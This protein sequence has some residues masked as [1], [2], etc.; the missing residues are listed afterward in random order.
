MEIFPTPIWI[1]DIDSIDN[2][3]LIDYSYKLQKR[4]PE[5]RDANG[6]RQNPT[7]LKWRSWYL[8][9]L[10]FSECT[11]LKKLFD[12]VN[13]KAELAFKQFNPNKTVKL[14]YNNSWINI[15]N[16]G[17]YIAPH[18]HPSSC[19]LVTYY[20]KV[21]PNSGNIVFLNPNNVITWNFPSGVYSNRN[22]YTDFQK[23]I[24]V[25]PGKFIIAPAH[26]QHFVEPNDSDDDRICV[27]FNY[28]IKDSNP[29]LSNDRNFTKNNSNVGM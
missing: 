6:Y 14:V 8:E 3:T 18:V 26:A 23:S 25:V 4:H 19:I 2:Q 13:Q 12:I 1:G 10:E 22:S 16:P 27:V 5:K 28:T 15:H 7:G 24:P 21:P 9:D 20:P 17:N 29:Y 11:E